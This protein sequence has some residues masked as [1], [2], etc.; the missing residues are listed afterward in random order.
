V[1]SLTIPNQTD[2]VNGKG[3]LSISVDCTGAKCTGNLTL[4]AKYKKTTGKGKKKKTKT[5]VLTI[6]T[7]SFNSLDL[8]VDTI[9]LKLNSKGQSLLAIDGYK[10]S[11]T[12]S[13][14]YLSG[15]VFK[16]ATGTL[17]LKGHKPSKKGVIKAIK[18]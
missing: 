12:A 15:S 1:S 17:K 16:T 3:D 14:T 18:L 8:G 13:A 2:D 7:A 11:S 5:I 6:G 10:L 4:V 9:S